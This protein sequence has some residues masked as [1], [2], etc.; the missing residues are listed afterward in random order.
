MSGTLAKLGQFTE[1]NAPCIFVVHTI[2][3]KPYYRYCSNEINSMKGAG[4]WGKY[5][6]F[7]TSQSMIKNLNVDT[8]MDKRGVLCPLYTVCM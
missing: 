4:T 3:C 1:K 7:T 8:Y 6:R 5:L 2:G